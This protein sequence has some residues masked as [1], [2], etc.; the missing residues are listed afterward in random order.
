MWHTP[1]E[2]NQISR[3]GISATRLSAGG[4]ACKSN[5]IGMFVNGWNNIFS[6]LRDGTTNT[7]F[8][9]ITSHYYL[10]NKVLGRNNKT[11]VWSAA[12]HIS[13]LFG[14]GEMILGEA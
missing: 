11:V 8:D 2:S 10:R 6:I 7:V 14:E 3:H 1:G 9:I 4:I 13:D 5:D 12:Y